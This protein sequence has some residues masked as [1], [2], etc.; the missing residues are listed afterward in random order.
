[1]FGSASH[2]RPI[3]LLIDELQSAYADPSL[4]A[5]L[6]RYIKSLLSGTSDMRVRI[7]AAAMYGHNPSGLADSSSTATA[8][9][10][11]FEYHP[12]NVVGLYPTA[13]NPLAL[14]LSEQEHQELWSMFWDGDIQYDWLFKGGNAQLTIYRETAGLVSA[15]RL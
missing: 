1:M 5:Q 11:P 15:G 12:R 2:E 7:V 10:A 9:S 4:Y 14:R 8:I 13:D 6:W 3:I